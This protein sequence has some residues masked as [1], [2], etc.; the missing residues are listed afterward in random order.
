MPYP[1]PASNRR[2]TPFLVTVL[3]AAAAAL[4]GPV[5]AGSA[6]VNCFGPDSN[7]NLPF[8][9]Y[10][11][12]PPPPVRARRSKGADDYR[13]YP[14]T[15]A[16]SMNIERLNAAGDGGVK[17]YYWLWANRCQGA[18]D[19]S[20]VCGWSGKGNVLFP[21]LH[22]GNAEVR[23]F[24]STLDKANDCTLAQGARVLG[25]E[26]AAV[27][28]YAQHSGLVLAEGGAQAMA[29]RAGGQLRDVC[30]L[31]PQTLD[32]GVAG[33]VLDYELGDNR[34]AAQTAD[35][36]Q[37]FAALVHQRGKQALLYTDA[38]D[39]PSAPHSGIDA[40]NVHRL[41]EQFDRVMLF[42]WHGNRQQDIT[43]SAESQWQM[44]RSGGD[45]DPGRVLAVFE[46]NHTSAEDSAAVRRLIL[47]RHLAGVMFW[48][49]LAAQGGECASDANRQTACLVF[50]RCSA[51]PSGQP[52]AEAGGRSAPASGSAAS[53]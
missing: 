35:F 5:I 42:L 29:R 37:R 12:A 47:E 38:W 49:D 31:S 16:A 6:A 27:R 1:L 53:D 4:C 13:Y 19:R 34:S 36:L 20:V 43:A 10:Q 9:V 45:V 40:S 25:A 28:G 11:Q 14:L 52:G 2:R 3:G 30:V 51:A 23:S 48:R 41:Y 44:L 22:D 18:N 21:P 8:E 39:A 24:F 50:G 15:A 33:I 17:R 46:L 32:R 7:K 26:D